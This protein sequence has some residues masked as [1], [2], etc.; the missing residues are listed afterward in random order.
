MVILIGVLFIIVGT[1]M[2]EKIAERSICRHEALEEYRRYRRYYDR[3]CA[4]HSEQ[5]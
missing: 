1:I 5:R 2:I 3:Y 4:E